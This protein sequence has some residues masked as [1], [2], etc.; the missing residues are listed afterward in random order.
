MIGIEPEIR[1]RRREPS[2][3]HGGT[4]LPRLLLALAL[5]A[6]VSACGAKEPAWGIRGEDSGRILLEVFNDNFQDARIFARWNGERQRLGLVT[7]NSSSRFEMRGRTGTLRIEVDFIAGGSFLSDPI[8][9]GPGE[10]LTFRI[11]PRR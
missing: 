5:V 4:R 6:L 9:V 7:G 2:P 1:K 10:N 8:Q 11:P 3:A